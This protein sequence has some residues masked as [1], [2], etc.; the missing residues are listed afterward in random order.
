MKQFD[1]E[2]RALAESEKTEIPYAARKR[3]A[4]VLA[5]LPERSVPAL[6]RRY[7]AAGRAV[8][9]TACL[10]LC[11]LVVLPNLSPAYAQAAERIPILGSLIRVV[12]IRNYFYEDASHELSVE[13]PFV[14]TEGAKEINCEIDTW[15]SELVRQFYAM[16][17]FILE[18][19]SEEWKSQRSDGKVIRREETDVI[20]QLVEYAKRQGSQNA[21]RLYITYSTLAQKTAGITS[22]ETATVVQLNTLAFAETVIRNVIAGC[23]AQEVP[24]KEIY[25]ICK[26][27][28]RE[29]AVLLSYDLQTQKG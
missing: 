16:R 14:K 23:M 15:T 21:D 1:H 4:S 5:S 2:L 7:P 18:K 26:E 25:R 28:L 11:I 19:Q 13:V 22:R 6:K 3:I 20:R 17:K 29:V 12:T 10:T 9:A 8:L 27:R 24:Y